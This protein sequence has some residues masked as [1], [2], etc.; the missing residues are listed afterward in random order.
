[1][2]QS[3]AATIGQNEVSCVVYGM[4]REA[5][6]LGAVDME[7]DIRGIIDYIKGME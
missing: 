3:G 7:K 4:P 6:K 1:M 2:K 5:V